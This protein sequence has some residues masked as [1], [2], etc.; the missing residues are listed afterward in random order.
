MP[1]VIKE[2]KK[3]I[4]DIQ[5][6]MIYRDL[7][8]PVGALDKARLSDFKQRYDECPEGS[9]RFLYGSHYSCPGYVIGFHLRSDPQWMIKF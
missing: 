5:D 9:E 2:Y 3:E 4:L 6:P 1:W 7:S 8:T